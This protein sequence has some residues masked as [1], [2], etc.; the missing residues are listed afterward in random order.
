MKSRWPVLSL[1]L[2]ALALAGSIIVGV[3]VPAHSNLLEFTAK[4]GGGTCGPSTGNSSAGPCPNEWNFGAGAF[5]VQ[6]RLNTTTGSNIT[7]SNRTVEQVIQASFATWL[8]APNTSLSPVTEGPPSAAT[9]PNSNDGVNL[10][11]FVCQPASFCDFVTEPDTIAFTVT[12]TADAVGLQIPGHTGSTTQFVGQILDAD[13]IFNPG[14]TFTTDAAGSSNANTQD[15]QTVATHEIGHFFGLD[16]TG[17]VRATMFPVAVQPLQVTL[18]YDDVA[19]ISALYP[20]T[21]K[22]VQTGAISGTVTLNG[23]AVFGAH[24]FAE[25]TTGAQ[26]FPNFIRKS[27]IS[28]LT[29]PNGTFQITGLPPDTYTVAAEPLDQPEITSDVAFY[30][31]AFPGN[32]TIQ[33]SFTTRWH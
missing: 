18:S 22:D 29:L 23:G 2:L 14:T 19:G 30:P 8:A 31:A 24:V 26:G 5:A 33:T 7:G 16:H 10:I 4:T 15:L 9:A 32:P 1:P 3:S 25:S 20:K 6:W 12:T 21:P 27:P 17:V 11:A 13:I 28:T